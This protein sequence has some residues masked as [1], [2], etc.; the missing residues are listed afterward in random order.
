[1]LGNQD[2][3]NDDDDKNDNGDENDDDDDEVDLINDASSW[4][5]CIVLSSPL[6]AR[7]EILNLRSLSSKF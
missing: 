4:Q 2:D 3:E 1:M 5:H 7:L 6:N